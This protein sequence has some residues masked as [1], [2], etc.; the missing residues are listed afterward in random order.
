M[1]DPLDELRAFEEMFRRDYP[2]LCQRVFRI[3]KD[4]EAA[5]DLVQEAF[6]S[7]WNKNQQRTIQSPEAYLHT[8]CI[9]KAITYA[10]SNKRKSQLRKE[11]YQERQADTGRTPEG[12]LESKEL[13]QRVQHAIE[14]LPPMCRK[15]FLL[16]R[17]EEMSHK[18]IAAFLGISPNTVDNHLKKALSLL[19]KALLGLLLMLP[20]IYFYFFC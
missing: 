20:E 16:S 3:I 2:L 6:I 15:V 14:T 1:A 18:E 17:H 13:E 7:Y 10:S 19:R 12:D 5:E 9:N 11:L 4:Q 8:A